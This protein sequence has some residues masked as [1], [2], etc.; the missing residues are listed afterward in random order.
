M[1]YESNKYAESK[2]LIWWRDFDF[3]EYESIIE[4][5][6]EWRLITTRVENKNA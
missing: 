4:I 6:G 3:N 1:I 2:V 5:N